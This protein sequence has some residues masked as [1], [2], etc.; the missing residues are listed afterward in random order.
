M[1]VRLAEKKGE[2]GAPGVTA[3]KVEAAVVGKH[4]L[5]GKAE[6]DARAI[7]LGGEERDENL[8]T[9]GRADRDAVI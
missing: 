3:D 1:T 6:A 2:A 5:T 7:A 8:L 4:D 9:R